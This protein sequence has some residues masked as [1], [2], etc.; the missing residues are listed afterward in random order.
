MNNADLIK[1]IIQNTPLSSHVLTK[2]VRL[3]DKRKA[4]R[5]LLEGKGVDAVYA[6]VRISKIYINNLRDY[7][8]RNRILPYTKPDA[9]FMWEMLEYGKNATARDVEIAKKIRYKMGREYIDISLFLACLKSI[10]LRPEDINPITRTV[11]INKARTYM[12][13][14]MKKVGWVERQPYMK[15]EYGYVNDEAYYNIVKRCGVQKTVPGVVGGRC[16]DI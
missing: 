4:V 16:I 14:L 13:K 8:Y 7:M 3:A 1:D 6:K 2:K 9:D 5:L 11:V 12:M 15:P 10:E